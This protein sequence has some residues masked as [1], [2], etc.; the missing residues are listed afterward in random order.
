MGLLK[1]SVELALSGWR[2]IRERRLLSLFQATVGLT[3][4][5]TVAERHSPFS[6]VEVYGEQGY[7]QR[8]NEA[9]KQR[10]KAWVEQYKLSPSFD[11]ENPEGDFVD[12]E[13]PQESEARERFLALGRTYYEANVQ[14]N[15]FEDLLWSGI[16]IKLVSGELVARGFREPFSY[17]A[18]YFTIPR[19]HWRVLRLQ[20]MTERAEGEGVA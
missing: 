15:A 9:R 17:D 11:A 14:S 12:I 19:H 5:W 7:L 10:Q 20:R 1:D 4:G 13:E 6:V 16:H 2:S 3:R 18:P 8:R